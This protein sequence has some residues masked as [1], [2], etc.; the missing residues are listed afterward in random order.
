MDIPVSLIRTL[1]VARCCTVNGMLGFDFYASSMYFTSLLNLPW[2]LL[3]YAY[4]GHVSYRFH[5]LLCPPV[6][7]L[8]IQLNLKAKH[9]RLIDNSSPTRIVMGSRTLRN[10]VSPQL[11]IPNGYLYK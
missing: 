1:D 3:L 8:S 10:P 9:Q 4:N 11:S 5:T 7:F 6:I 2:F